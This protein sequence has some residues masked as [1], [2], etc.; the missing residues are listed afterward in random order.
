MDSTSPE[1]AASNNGVAPTGSICGGEVGS[2][3]GLGIRVPSDRGTGATVH[4]SGRALVRV[5]VV[6]KPNVGKSSF[7][8]RLLGED[9]LVVYD[10]P[11][12]TRDYVE[13]DLELDRY[14]CVLVDMTTS[15][16]S[17]PRISG[18]APSQ[19]HV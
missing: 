18:G 7:V 1:A 16:P 4:A 9:R 15:E 8:N 10:Q 3:L 13:A 19:V 5:A 17:L 12:T 2:R 14:G 6:G 11:G